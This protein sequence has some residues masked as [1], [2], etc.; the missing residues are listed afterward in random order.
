MFLG[1]RRVTPRRRE[2]LRCLID[3]DSAKE[4][5]ARCGCSERYVRRVKEEAMRRLGARN[6]YELARYVMRRE[7]RETPAMVP[8][9][10]L[11]DP[12]TRP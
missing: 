4:T 6:S 9:W 1:E 8:I 2:I 12:A 10:H 3:T 11:P 5:A 7:R